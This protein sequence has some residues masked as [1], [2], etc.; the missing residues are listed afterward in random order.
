MTK[1]EDEFGMR[2]SYPVLCQKGRYGPV[3]PRRRADISHSALHS[4]EWTANEIK[5]QN[6]ASRD[7]LIEVKFSTKITII[8]LCQAGNPQISLYLYD[9]SITTN[10]EP[11]NFQQ[12]T[13]HREGQ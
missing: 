2:P 6:M 4:C 5:R 7:F 3:P 10:Y 8:R 9:L 12:E 13:D 1:I 11:Y